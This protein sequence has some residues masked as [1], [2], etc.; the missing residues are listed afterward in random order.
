MNLYKAQNSAL[1]QIK[2]LSFTLEKDIQS[3]VETNINDIFGYLFISTEFSIGEY[4]IDTLCF[5]EEN[6]SFVIIEYKKGSS[7]SVI[8]QGYSYL[9]TMLN[10]KAEFILEYNEKTEATLK[11]DEVNW[12]SSKVLFISPS[13]NSYQKNSVN[14][15]DVPFELWEIKR[16]EGSLICLEQHK[17]TSKESI[18]HITGDSLIQSVSKEVKSY[19]EEDVLQKS[20]EQ[21]KQSWYQ[22]KE[23]L[24]ELDDSDMVAGKGYIKFTKNGKGVCYFSFRKSF[25]NAEIIRGNIKTDGSKSKNFFVID[26]PKNIVRERH[27]TWKSG[28]EGHRYL[29]DIKPSIDLGKV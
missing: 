2:E 21:T 19:K 22:L 7:Y 3:L 1:N 16:F 13:F 27:F 26:D 24:L 29:F 28:E 10:N 5:D 15:K 23:K 20:D 17:A 8:D 12:A 11:R 9:S 4:R 25:F 6:N 18:E 14:F